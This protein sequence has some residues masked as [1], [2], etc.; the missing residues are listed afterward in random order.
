MRCSESFVFVFVFVFSSV[1]AFV[2]LSLLVF[3]CVFVFVF[4]L[5]CNERI[6]LPQTERA[7]LPLSNFSF[8]L[9]NSRGKS[10]A[11]WPLASTILSCG[12]FCLPTVVASTNTY[13]GCL[14]LPAVVA[15]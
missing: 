8:Q 3:V 7:T 12:C 5:V 14:C 1:F 13:C 2:F 6:S 15:K 11:I 4:L 9:Q 10:E